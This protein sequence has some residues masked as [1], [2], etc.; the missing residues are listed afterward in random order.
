MTLDPLHDETWT[1]QHRVHRGN[2][3]DNLGAAIRS[4]AMSQ[5]PVAYV[6]SAIE[7]FEDE[8]A[9]WRYAELA[10]P[11]IEHFGGRFIVSNAEPAVLEGKSPSGHLSM[12]E[13]PS[14]EDAKAWYDSPE[15]AEARAITPA[16]FRGRMLMFVAGVKPPR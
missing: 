9:V 1:Q 13:F 16:A 7:G 6:I 12:V 8:A 5:P 11:A 10:G 3:L 14:I 15:Y 4:R 2:E